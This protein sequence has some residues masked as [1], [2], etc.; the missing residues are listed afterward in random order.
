MILSF[1]KGIILTFESTNN[2]QSDS[3]VRNNIIKGILLFLG[4]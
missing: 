2:V 3:R 1:V 4:S